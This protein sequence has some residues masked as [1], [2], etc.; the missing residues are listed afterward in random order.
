MGDGE[1]AMP[2]LQC[3]LY[4]ACLLCCFWQPGI[5]QLMVADVLWHLR[6][7]LQSAAAVCPGSF[8]FKQFLAVA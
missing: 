3:V 5:P 4:T 8:L 7:Q 6:C 2:D 1:Q